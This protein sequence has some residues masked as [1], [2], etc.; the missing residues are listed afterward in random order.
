MAGNHE[1]YALLYAVEIKELSKQ[2]INPTGILIYC[3]LAMHCRAGS[4]CYPS[5]DTIRECI[6]N[7]YSERQLWRGI[8]A[9]KDAG[10]V[11]TGH[12]R[13]KER[14]FLPWRVRPPENDI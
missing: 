9:L 1:S 4:T 10:M 7:S 14:F 8:K 6:G 12:R 3:V 13:S 2:R 11:I 5:I